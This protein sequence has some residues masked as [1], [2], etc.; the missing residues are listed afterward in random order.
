LIDLQIL[1]QDQFVGVVGGNILDLDHI[2]KLLQELQSHQGRMGVTF[3]FHELV[4]SILQD[5]N[6][7][8]SIRWEVIDSM[9]H[10]THLGG[11]AAVRIHCMDIQA[12][13]AVLRWYACDTFTDTDQGFIDQN[14][15]D[16]SLCDCDCRVFQ[17]FLWKE[18]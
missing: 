14:E 5:K 6:P 2:Q 10:A 13:E 4:I 16:E 7:R 3:F 15:W 17:A 9:P 8:G 12:L 1:Q 11:I 18:R